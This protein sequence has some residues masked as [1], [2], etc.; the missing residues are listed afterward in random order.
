M[1]ELLDDKI[2]KWNWSLRTTVIVALIFAFF[3]GF[4]VAVLIFKIKHGGD[5]DME[6]INLIL[7][8]FFT[9]RCGIAAIR[10]GHGPSSSNQ[11][12]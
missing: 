1:F 8:V 5:W 3:A 9:I 4:E 2:K 10:K 6:I 7:P 11:L 12:S